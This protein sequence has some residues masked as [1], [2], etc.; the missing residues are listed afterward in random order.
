[1]LPVCSSKHLDYSIQNDHCLSHLR[2][3]LQDA[4]VNSMTFMEAKP[5]PHLV[6]DDALPKG[7][8]QHIEEYGRRLKNMDSNVHLNSK[9]FANQRVWEFDSDIQNKLAWFYSKQFEELIAEYTGIAELH[10]DPEY[11][12]G[13]GYHLLPDGGFLNVHKDFNHH[14]SA[15]GYFRRL[16]FILYLNKNWTEKMGGQLELVDK[17]NA[18][19][20]IQVVPLFNRAVIFETNDEAWH[21][22]PTPVNNASQDRLSFATFYYTK[23]SS[24]CSDEKRSTLYTDI[25][26]Q[27]TNKIRNIVMPIKKLLPKSVWASVRKQF[28]K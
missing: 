8:V 13:G 16:N 21:G 23:D 9:K 5:F 6:I 26:G 3:K 14:P 15:E 28:L 22:N 18:E 24:H 17:K 19:N 20:T 25:G 27:Y 10:S 7:F 11:N 1:M 12:I 2:S 4:G